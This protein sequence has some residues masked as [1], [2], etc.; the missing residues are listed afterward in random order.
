MTGV[1]GPLA[2]GFLVAA[3]RHSSESIAVCAAFLAAVAIA[4]TMSRTMRHFP[5]VQ[6]PTAATE[7]QPEQP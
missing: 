4:T 1:L 5:T 2:A 3:S 6:L 7:A